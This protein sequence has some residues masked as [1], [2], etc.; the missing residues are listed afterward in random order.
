MRQHLN[1]EALRLCNSWNHSPWCT[2]G[3]GGDGHLGHSWGG[4]GNYSC[5]SPRWMRGRTSIP[6]LPPKKGV[7]QN[8][9]VY[10]S[11]RQSM[12]EL[13]ADLGYS[14]LFP[15]DCRYCGRRI[16]LFAS[17]EGGFAI[18][19]EIGIPWPKHQCWGVRSNSRD[20]RGNKIYS[21][22]YR[23]PIERDLPAIRTRGRGAIIGF[24]VDQVIEMSSPAYLLW[25]GR[26]LLRIVSSDR[27]EKGR[28]YRG[29]LSQDG[30]YC[31]FVQPELIEYPD[32]SALQNARVESEW[33]VNEVWYLQQ[34]AADMLPFEQ[35]IRHHLLASIDAIVSEN[36]VIAAVILLSL[37]R[38]PSFSLTAVRKNFYRVLG[39][40]LF[41]SYGF[42]YV[43]NQGIRPDVGARKKAEIRIEEILTES[44]LFVARLK[45]HYGIDLGSLMKS[46]LARLEAI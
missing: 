23:V 14:V 7:I 40:Q 30:E 4:G 16:Y 33:E 24:C 27:L 21:D 36:E 29:K 19:D 31:R 44:S 5:P 45:S 43:S 28:L 37:S 15:T 25:D 32:V 20:Y 34:D 2:C 42:K 46:S 13:A 41:E 39:V 22:M 35:E 6:W 26:G 38:I 11:Y 1:S 8:V 9:Q 18:F 12:S 3:F 17:P 10:C